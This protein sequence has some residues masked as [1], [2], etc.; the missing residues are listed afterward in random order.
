MVEQRSQCPEHTTQNDPLVCE[1]N[2]LHYEVLQHHVARVSAAQHPFEAHA[3]AR[4]ALSL[5]HRRRRDRAEP[6]LPSLN[7]LEAVAHSLP[8]RRKR[9]SNVLGVLALCRV[10]ANIAE[11]SNDRLLDL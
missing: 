5:R 2:L 1:V 3:V 6:F 4:R 9:P 8:D 11:T 10:K 7:G